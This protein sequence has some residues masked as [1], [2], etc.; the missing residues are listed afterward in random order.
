MEAL[1]DG[2]KIKELPHTIRQ[3]L[4]YSEASK[5]VVD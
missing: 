4:S 5:I 3:W 1:L 2:E